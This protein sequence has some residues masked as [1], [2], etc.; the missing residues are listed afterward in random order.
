MFDLILAVGS[1]KLADSTESSHYD[2]GASLMGA[3][4]LN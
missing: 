3:S 2:L 1:T 4:R